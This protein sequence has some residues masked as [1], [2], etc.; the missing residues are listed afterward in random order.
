MNELIKRDNVGTANQEF[1]SNLKMLTLMMAII[2]LVNIPTIIVFISPSFLMN[3]Q[4]T[5]NLICSCLTIIT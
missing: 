2:S 5:M 3:Y 1:V 4:S